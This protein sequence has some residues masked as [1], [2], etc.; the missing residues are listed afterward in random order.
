VL[1]VTVVAVSVG[2]VATSGT[3][4]PVEGNFMP[5]VIRW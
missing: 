3:E 2:V 1:V 4:G 5:G